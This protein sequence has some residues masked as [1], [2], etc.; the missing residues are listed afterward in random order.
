MSV[1]RF[2]PSARRV[3]DFARVNAAALAVLPELLQRWLPDGKRQGAEYLARNPRRD[4]HRMGSFRI[5]LMTGRWADFA[6]DD[7]RGGDVVSLLAYLDGCRQYEA[8][9][10]LTEILA[11]ERGHD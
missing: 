4:D 6:T 1:R 3:V 5:N 8:V 7:A 10:K 2:S 9:Q 11:I